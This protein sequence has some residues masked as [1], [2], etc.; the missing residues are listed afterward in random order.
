[1]ETYFANFIKTGNPNGTR[2]PRWPAAG[3]GDTVQVMVLNVHPRAEPER[4]KEAYRF[5]DGFY[6]GHPAP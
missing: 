4:N 2:L 5:L 1:M 3:R 6:R